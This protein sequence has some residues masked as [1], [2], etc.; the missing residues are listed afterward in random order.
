MQPEVYYRYDPTITA[1]WKSYPVRLRGPRPS[2]CHMAPTLLVRSMKQGFV[3]ANCCE[4]GGRDTLRESEFRS[5]NLWVS[6]PHCQRRMWPQ[7][8]SE[9][10]GEALHAGNY[11]YGCLECRVYFLLADLLP[12]WADIRPP[13]GTADYEV[14]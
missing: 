6:C 9:V 7:V 4:C 12:D 8:L 10:R 2:S 13:E 3:T 14:A 11:A 1:G 5:L